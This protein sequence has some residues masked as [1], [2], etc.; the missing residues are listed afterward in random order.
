MIML[1]VDFEVEA[2]KQAAFESV[3]DRLAAATL[4]HE[5]GTLL[6]Q[7]AAVDDHSGHYRLV[8]LY[9]DQAS[10][11]AHLASEWFRSADVE[12]RPLLGKRPEI[13]RHTTVNDSFAMKRA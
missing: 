7:L 13:I 5:A 3:M 10:A 2:D 1:T 11:D 9:C 12:M 6:Y 8:E 4:A